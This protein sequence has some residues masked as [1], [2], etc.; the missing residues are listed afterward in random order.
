MKIGFIGLGIMGEPMA[1]NLLKAGFPLT[2]FNR[3]ARRM[4]KLL[5]AGAAGAY[6]PREVAAKSDVVITIVTDSPDV[7]EVVLGENGI[8]SGLHTGSVVIDMSTISPA[9]TRKLAAEIERK[10][11]EM[12]DAPVSGGDIGAIAGTLAIMVGGK[13]EVFQGCLPVLEAMGKSVTWI[14]GHGMGQTVKLCNQILG[15]VTNL[16]VCEAVE[17]ARK[18]GV[19]P[20]VMIEAVKGGAAG[21]WQLANLGPKMVAGN[22]APGFMI[23]LQQKDLRLAL[24]AAREMQLP[25]PALALVQQLFTGCQAHGEGREGTQALVKSLRRLGGNLQ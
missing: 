22:F 13:K 3:T 1:L 24:E 7:E 12:L 5:A 19:D 14:G 16:A 10:G 21:S 25:A 15:A 2:V 20:L 17:F 4:D 8:L 6:S 18:A 9:V 23:D 11:G